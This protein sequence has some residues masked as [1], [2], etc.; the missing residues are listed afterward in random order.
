MRILP[1][2]AIAVFLALP[3]R[4]QQAPDGIT[5]TIERQMQAFRTGDLTITTAASR[6]EIVA[7]R[8]RGY[9][10]VIGS[11]DLPEGYVRHHQFTDE[12]VAIEPI[13]MFAPDFTLYDANGRP[14]AMPGNRVVPPGLAPPGLPIRRVR[15]PPSP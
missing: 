12:G 11:F 9:A 13:L 3:L 15:I 5:A 7:G 14:I 10:T 6:D 4:A 2:L 8:L 1:C